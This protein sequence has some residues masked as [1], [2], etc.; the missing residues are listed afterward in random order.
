MLAAVLTFITLYLHETLL[1]IFFAMPSRLHAT[2]FVVENA[3]CQLPA[4]YE[5]VHHMPLSVMAGR[6]PNTRVLLLLSLYRVAIC[7]FVSAV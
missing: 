4:T 1:Y 3:R 2:D 6:E 7:I 5:H